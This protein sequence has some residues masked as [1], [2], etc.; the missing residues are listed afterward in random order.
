MNVK[1][2]SLDVARAEITQLKK[3]CS[4]LEDKLE[5]AQHA[6]TTAAEERMANEKELQ[7][8]HNENIQ[9]AKTE[10]ASTARAEAE[11]ARLREITTV[12][13]QAASSERALREE[14]KL[15]VC[16]HESWECGL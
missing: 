9:A 13:D 8:V 2:E 14:H 16:L 15:E 5:A 11:A 12:T 1:T 6:L 7:N 4:D 10:A 3:H